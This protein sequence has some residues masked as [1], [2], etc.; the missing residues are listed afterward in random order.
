[1]VWC[2]ILWYRI[3]LYCNSDSDINSNSN[4]SSNSDSVSNSNSNGNSNSNSDGNVDGLVWSECVFRCVQVFENT[5]SKNA[6]SRT[7][8]VRIVF[9]H[10]VCVFGCVRTH[11]CVFGCVRDVCF[12]LSSL[13]RLPSGERGGE[14][15]RALLGIWVVWLCSGCVRDRRSMWVLD[16]GPGPGPGPGT[17]GLEG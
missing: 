10:N 15:K 9:D 8:C 2:G 6:C 1:M 11:V 12:P 3:V 17:S 4:G 16:L 13:R 7:H 14:G 5:C